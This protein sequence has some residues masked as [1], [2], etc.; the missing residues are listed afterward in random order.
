MTLFLFQTLVFC[1][2]VFYTLVPDADQIA[3]NLKVSQFDCVAMTENTLYALKQVRHRHNTLE[4]LE[5]SQN[6]IFL[7][8]EHFR[9]KLNAIKCRIQH[10]KEKWHCG[11]NDHSSIDHTV[12][13]I[14]S[15]LLISPQQCRSLA[16]E[17]MI[18]FADHFLG[19]EYDT[20]N[21]IVSTDGSTSNNKKNH[22]M[23]RSLI[24]RDTF[25]PPPS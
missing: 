6:K 21:L 11:Q 9:K 8:T 13:G 22:C 18:Y 12:A 16:K 3:K 17:N 25:L 20:K 15:E 7:Y 5:I 10:Q 14:I 4:E 19:V 2:E 24:T 23:A 1:S